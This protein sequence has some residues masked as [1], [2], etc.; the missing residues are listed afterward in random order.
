V[1]QVTNSLDLVFDVPGP[2]VA[3]T[4]L[5]KDIVFFAKLDSVP[6]KQFN[7]TLVEFAIQADPATQTFR[8]RVA[9]E[10]PEIYTILPGMS[11]TI[12]V[13]EKQASASAFK[14]PA[15][16]IS[17]EPDGSVFVWV[18]TQ[19]DNR[20][21]KRA[22]TVGEISG[23]DMLVL[24]GIESGDIVVTAGTPHLQVQMVVRPITEIGD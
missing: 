22:V 14:L 2:D 3:T 17:S 8:G 15:S 21:E 13:T 5:R 1:L 20:V 9:I 6:D 11:G 7:A 12:I 16:A 18:V 24:G 19:P 4:G 23:A 10:R